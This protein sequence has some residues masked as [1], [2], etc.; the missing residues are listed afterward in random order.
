MSFSDLGIGIGP[1]FGQGVGGD[2]VL[3]AFADGTD[4][5]YFDF[6]KTD[7][8]FQNLT[9]TAV[10]SGGDN[11]YLGLESHAWSGLSFAGIVSAAT[12]IITNGGFDSDTLWTKGAGWSIAAGVAAAVAVAAGQNLSHNTAGGVANQLYRISYDISAYTSGG[13]SPSIGVS[14]TARTS[15][16]AGLKEMLLASVTAVLSFVRRISDFTGSIDNVSMKLIPGNHG[17]QATTSLQPKWQ[18]GGLAR[19]DGLDDNLLTTLLPSGIITLGARLKPTS[20][21]R[22]LMGSQ[23]GTTTRAAISIGAGG[24][25]V[26]NFGSS[27]T[28]TGGPDIRGTNATVFGVCDGTVTFLYVN[29]VLVAS[30]A[31]AGTINTTIPIMLGCT[32][33]N[34]VA[35]GFADVDFYKAL[36]IKK[37]LSAAEIAAITNKWSTL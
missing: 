5:F 35:A 25:A 27:N 11:I 19:F 9:E 7:R 32:S 29:N 10:A 24:L 22:F 14:G 21:S 13:I 16:G 20:G 8:L 18:T 33:N 15:A 6:S 12:E 26:A 4:G 1:T 30:E 17:L 36:V 2:P 31:R 34:G 3:A 28:L 23:T 37:A